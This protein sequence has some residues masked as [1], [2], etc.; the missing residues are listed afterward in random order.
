[1][2]TEDTCT[3]CGDTFIKTFRTNW[4]KPCRTRIAREYRLS[5][6]EIVRAAYK[7]DQARHRAERN[8]AK[9]AYRKTGA[10]KASDRLSAKVSR[11]RF[12]EKYQGRLATNRLIRKGILIR[13]DH[14]P[15]CGATGR[16]EGHHTDYSKPADILWLCKRCHVRAHGREVDDARIIKS[17]ELEVKAKLE[18]AK[19]AV[20][21][22]SI[23]QTW[24]DCDK[25]TN[26]RQVTIQAMS[27]EYAYVL[28]S[29]GRHTKIKLNRF[30]PGNT[31][32]RFV[33]DH[34]E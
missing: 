32:Y 28:A 31:G 21:T 13:P 20:P 4:C 30:K 16:I 27:S 3:K 10:N 12:P 34:N 29:N 26:G 8:A 23:G 24:A 25:R 7:R 11:E 9:R 5:H 17:F 14:C 2:E 1:M 22:P 19:A 15:E 33:G 18:A 6:P